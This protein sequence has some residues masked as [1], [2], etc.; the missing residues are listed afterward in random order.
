[1]TL[2][3]KNFDTVVAAFCDGL[4][5]KLKSEKADSVAIT[6]YIKAVN[7]ARDYTKEQFDGEFGKFGGQFTSH[8][9][10]HAGRVLFNAMELAHRLEKPL[11]ARE[12]YTLGVAA[13]VH[14]TGMT[15]PLPPLVVEACEN[16][17]Q[18]WDERRKRHG[19][20]A[21]SALLECKGAHLQVIANADRD[22]Y[23]FIPDIC[24]AHCTS[25]FQEHLSTIRR[26]ADALGAGRRYATI[27]GILLLADE[28][29]ICCE[30]ARPDRSRYHELKSPLTKAH[31]WKHWIVSNVEF[32]GGLLRITRISETRLQHSDEFAQWTRAKLE[33]QLRVLRACLDP[34]RSER[35][36]RIE[37]SLVGVGDI[38][39]SDELPDLSLDVVEAAQ[40]ARLKI[41]GERIT[42]VIDPERL[43][44]KVQ[45]ADACKEPSVFFREAIAKRI[46]H[47]RGQGQFVSPEEARRLYV[48]DQHNMGLME[49]A[50]DEWRRYVSGETPGV[51]LKVFVGDIGVGK[52]HFLSVFLHEL[53][54]RFPELSQ[55][56]LAARAELTDRDPKNLLD[57][58]RW[59]ARCLYLELNKKGL[60][61]N[62][63]RDLMIEAYT[64]GVPPQVPSTVEEIGNW[65]LELINGFIS[66]IG[67]ICKHESGIRPRLKSEAPDALCLF[68]DNSDHLSADLVGELYTWCNNI[69]GSSGCLLWMFLRPVTFAQLQMKHQQAAVNLRAPEP[70]YAPTLKQV[71]LKRMDTLPK[72][73]HPTD[74]VTLPN[75]AIAFGQP[76]TFTPMDVK[77]AVSYV[78]NLALE[79]SDDMLSQ[80]TGDEQNQTNLRGGLAALVGILGSHVITDRDYADALLLRPQVALAP[81]A[82]AAHRSGIEKW[83][84][85]LEALILGRRIWYSPKCGAIENLLDPPRVQEYGDY[86]LFLHILQVL[87]KKGTEVPFGDIC[88]RLARLGY[89]RGRIHEAVQ[90]LAGREVISDEGNP[91]EDPFVKRTFPLVIVAS[92]AQDG[93]YRD[94]TIIRATPWGD[95]HINTLVWQAQYW[96]HM[97]YQIM[98]PSSLTS[99][100]RPDVLRDTG[101]KLAEQLDGVLVYLASIEDAWL[102]SSSNDQLTE[103]GIRRVMAKIRER[104]PRQLQ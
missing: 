16:D 42:R 65:P 22:A 94:N 78:T 14:D 17:D 64:P 67:T 26:K 56:S 72:R 100:L 58:Q 18:R 91:D 40:Q 93:P 25:G 30:R 92:S 13:I 24:A 8:G 47:F 1:M 69:S 57:A 60:L 6:S 63:I 98:L 52:T 102:Y 48:E 84:R 75:V 62:R 81:G 71:V 7:H 10:D 34:D 101:S 3:N 27:A 23:S 21:A 44:G 59:V 32:D 43:I 37:I 46:S 29:D 4:R 36:W 77:D 50:I 15:A 33:H 86:F 20:A 39:W 95:Y 35:L 41:P 55:K 79:T 82:V 88:F 103:I 74:K 51:N 83:P 2:V 70:I 5:K 61:A 97:F 28:L 49:H 11:S 31:W 90:Y 76:V 68:L 85:V 12:M 89:T 53:A 66:T 73:F 104:V 45:Q 99:G 19:E 38:W 96:K 87:T 9:P 54:K 80:L